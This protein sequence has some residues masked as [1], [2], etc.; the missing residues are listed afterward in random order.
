MTT[1]IFKCEFIANYSHGCWIDEHW[2]GPVLISESSFSQ[3][4]ESGATIKSE[5]LPTLAE[6]EIY[7]MRDFDRK[8]IRPL[9]SKANV[10]VPLGGPSKKKVAYQSI[11]SGMPIGSLQI[12]DCQFTENK[13]NGLVLSSV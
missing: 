1:K 10:I 5:R 4:L 3:N 12:I 7:L 2:K 11:L 8:G 6:E 9:M 13:Y